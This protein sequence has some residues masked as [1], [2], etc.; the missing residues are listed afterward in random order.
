M[1]G[2]DPLLKRPH[3]A[4]DGL[5][6]PLLAL[7]QGRDDRIRQLK[8]RP[9]VQPARLDA[10]QHRAGLPQRRLGRDRRVDGAVDGH[11][12]AGADKLVE[13]DV[14][15][16]AARAELGGVQDDEDVVAVGPDLGH[17]VALDAGAD[18]EGWKPKTSL[19]SWAACWS[20][21]GMSTQTS[22]SSRVS[23]C[24]SS[25]TGCCWMPSSD[26]KCTS[27]PPATSWKQ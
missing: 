10:S 19:S 14:V 13:L 17:G 11:D 3:L 25:P 9:R 20:Q 5:H 27:I 24:S 7:G 26:T 8:G 4:G 12:I 22:P 21:T 1:P 18:G 16:V 15:D 23:S 6:E 2:G